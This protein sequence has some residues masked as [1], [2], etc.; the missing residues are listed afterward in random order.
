MLIIWKECSLFDE[1]EE[2]RKTE[3]IDN[4]ENEKKLN[5]LI[6]TEEKE[7]FIKKIISNKALEFEK[8]SFK[9]KIQQEKPAKIGFYLKDA[10][11]VIELSKPKE[12]QIFPKFTT[13]FQ[14]QFNLKCSKCNTAYDSIN[15]D[16]EI[17]CFRED[18]L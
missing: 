10:F 12:L 18:T 7:R 14:G 9:E 13:P 8:E 2:T 6:T 1:M 17:V 16:E 4:L 5:D 11:I 15:F 3:I